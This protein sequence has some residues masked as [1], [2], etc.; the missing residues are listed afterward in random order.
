MNILELTKMISAHRNRRVNNSNSSVQ[1][2][3]QFQYEMNS[4]DESFF[5]K[6]G[7][8]CE[9]IKEL[10]EQK[11]LKKNK[12]NK[13]TIRFV[14]I[15]IPRKP[16]NSEGII[17]LPKYLSAIEDTIPDSELEQH[18]G[19]ILK[20]LERYR[21]SNHRVE[22][23]DDLV[24]PNIFGTE[25][26]N[27]LALADF[28]I[29]DYLAHGIYRKTAT[30]YSSNSS[31]RIDWNRTINQKTP[32][33]S[34]STMI[35]PETIKKRNEKTY[36]PTISNFHR[37]VIAKYIRDYGQILGYSF[38]ESIVGDVENNHT[39]KAQLS[40]QSNS[41]L[42]HEL[43]KELRLTFGRKNITLIRNLLNVIKPAFNSINP[44]LVLGTKNFENLWEEIIRE[45]LDSNG[46]TNS[47]NRK[48]P[49]AKWWNVDQKIIKKSPRGQPI[50]DTIAKLG[51]DKYLIA[52]AKYY[53]LD[54]D[55]TNNQFNGKGP[56]ISDVMKQ[57]MYEQIL[58][59][60]IK[61]EIIC[62][63]LLIFPRY[64][65]IDD[66]IILPFG[67]VH[68]PIPKLPFV[69]NCF[70]DSQQLL[71]NYS[72]SIVANDSQLQKLFSITKNISTL[73]LDKA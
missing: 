24:F 42:W 37:F 47:I 29:K 59:G 72:R 13:L 11:I 9:E 34:G 51:N 48:Y 36:H 33:V 27:H 14:G 2:S 46:M 8:T 3:F 64:S 10:I 62:T 70:G 40:S 67:T 22:L 54:Y 55:E 19:L 49:R 73:A 28:F 35:Y 26:T 1:T 44:M 4:Q 43:Q 23:E 60:I 20:S 45:Y 56:G 32:L 30:V 71:K 39:I 21:C 15:I 18:F 17:V 58:R 31:G 53:D 65:L 7:F 57:V 66:H 25:S 41:H 12:S 50:T 68:I 6:I 5:L 38:D 61:E 52:D 63:N 69:V 16:I